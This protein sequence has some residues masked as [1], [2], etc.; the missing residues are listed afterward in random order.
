MELYIHIPFCIRKCAYCDFLSAP[1]DD[2]T[3]ENYV[4]ALIR[5]IRLQAEEDEKIVGNRISSIYI[6]GGTPTV[7]SPDQIRRIMDAVT[8]VFEICDDAEI[9]IE[10]NPGTIS[11]EKLIAC[12]TSGINR[13]SIGLQSADDEELKR[14]GRIHTYEDFLQGW[15]MARENG[16]D[17]INVDLV[18]AIPGQTVQSYEAGIRKVLLLS[19]EHI[20]AYSLIIEEGTPFMQLYG[21]HAPYEA[22]LPSEEEER[23][24]YK[25]TERLLHEAG[26]RR[27]EI[28]NYAKPGREGR[29]NLGYWE[30]KEYLGVGTGAASLLAGVRYKNEENLRTY[31]SVLQGEDPL[32]SKIRHV[33]QTLT[34]QN[35]MEEFFFLGLRKTDGV[36]KQDFYRMFDVP[37]EEIYGAQMT[38]LIRQGLLFDDGQK[39]ALTEKGLDLANFVFAEFLL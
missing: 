12:K 27:Y 17:N 30:R 11:K 15:H 28:S 34:R 5:E 7:L 14:L 39:L 31:L 21:E 4:R 25:L 32:L 6:G 20:S 2:D 29:H 23:I 19:P 9:T 8:D 24:M 13:L 26:Y 18:A 16:F 22:M 38:Q 33:E 35:E 3:R 36:K 1:A 10:A 37:A